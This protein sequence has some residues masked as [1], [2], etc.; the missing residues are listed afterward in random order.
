MIIWIEKK[1]Q[2]QL[3]INL[4][5]LGFGGLILWLLISAI[6]LGGFVTI[7]FTSIGEIWIELVLLSIV[8]IIGFVYLLYSIGEDK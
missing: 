8:L 5:F 3:M 6:Y 4:L 7:D 2:L 1:E